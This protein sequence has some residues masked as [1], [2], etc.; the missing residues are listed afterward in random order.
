M[1]VCGGAFRIREDYTPYIHVEPVKP[2]LPGRELQKAVAEFYKRNPQA[3]VLG[4]RKTPGFTIVD[5]PFYAFA[6]RGGYYCTITRGKP[7][8]TVR[9]YYR[10][11]QNQ[12]HWLASYQ[13]EFMF[14][15]K[16]E[17]LFA[18]KQTV[19]HRKFHFTSATAT[20]HVNY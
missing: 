12:N 15:K 1:Y 13:I 11:A 9:L 7:K 4:W 5:Q 14:N 19:T 16:A 3:Q 18:I 6:F 8:H 10:D 20:S 2:K 17:A